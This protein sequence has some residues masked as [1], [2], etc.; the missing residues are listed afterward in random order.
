MLPGRKYGP[1]QILA[2]AWQRRWVIVVPL[3][4]VTAGAAVYA[5]A[6]PD[7]FRSETTILV[8]PQ[9]VPESY[10]R[11]TVTSRI[12]DRLQSLRQQILSRARLEQIIQEFKLYPQARVTEP[13]EQI[14]E[15]MRSAV[16]VDIVR[17]DAF[18]IAYTSTDRLSA[19]LVVER[20]AS[21]FIEENLR[22]REVLADGTSDFLETQLVQARQRLEEHEEK[23]AAYR[24]Q[25]SGELPSQLDSNLQ[26]LHSLNLQAQEISNDI[27]R[28]RDRMMVL[29]RALIE[30]SEPSLLGAAPSSGAAVM[31]SSALTRLETAR[32]ALDQLRTRLKPEHPD[33]GAARRLVAE[34]ERQVAAEGS[35]QPAMAEGMPS[36][37]TPASAARQR[38]AQEVRLE[39]DNLAGQITRKQLEEQ[40]IRDLVNL[41]QTRV[42]GTPARE[43]E[44][45]G[46]TRDYETLQSLYTS[47]LAKKEESVVAA[48]LE[49]RQVG[50]QFRVL[51]PARVP[52]Q[53]H[54]PNRTRI[55]L[56]GVVAGLVIGLG[57]AAFIEYRDATVKT[58]DDIL[59]C[60]ALPMLAAIPVLAVEVQASS[61]HRAAAL[62]V[63]RVMRRLFGGD[64]R[65][66]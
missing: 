54:S 18:I 41:Y 40:R 11:A 46:L 44:L 38:R 43:T 12:E 50:E 17:G 21:L 42:E 49:R 4:L 25:Y 39:K 16:L 24:R 64:A 28:D 26:I 6:L 13:I 66:S 32:T 29:D 20:L 34:L 8:V 55:N 10:V 59:T 19:K 31:S 14:V 53:P 61:R 9:R 3:F 5:R 37:T 57:L 1:E 47:L 36:V 30:V 65:E 27:E 63:S 23:L 62:G 51:D 35:P 45:I 2:L 48:N 22:E 56:L 58:E 60:L 7:M 52:E 33:V 15:R